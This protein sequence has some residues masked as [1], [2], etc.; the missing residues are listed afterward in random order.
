MKAKRSLKIRL[1]ALGLSVA[2]I[3]LV[4]LFMLSKRQESQV[5][6]MVR[7]AMIDQATNDLS[8][9]VVSILD[10]LEVSNDMLKINIQKG[11]RV[12]EQALDLAGGI[13]FDSS[14]ESVEWTAVNQYTSNKQTVDLPVVRFGD[15]RSIQ[16]VSSFDD[17][18]PI[19]D[20]I[21][22]L[23]DDT[24]TIFQRMNEAGD[25]L[26]IATTVN[27][28]GQRA[29]GTYIPAVNPDGKP[30]PVIKEIMAGKTFRGRA[31][32]VDQYYT[33][34]YKPL[35]DSKGK[36]SGILY[37][38]LPER[39][40]TDKILDHLAE[41]KV[42]TTGYVYILNARGAD[43]GRYVLSSKRARDGEIIINAK[44]ANGRLFIQDM[45]EKAPTLAK[46]EIA[47]IEYPWINPGEPEPRNKL[48]EYAYY[49]DWDWLIGVGSYEEEFYSAVNEVE[50]TFSRYSVVMMVCIIIIAV[51]AAGLFT[52]VT[53]S[54]TRPIEGIIHQLGAGSDETAGAAGEV[55][56]ASQ[57]LAEGASEQAA[58]LEETQASMESLKDL[59]DRNTSVAQETRTV[60]V[61][62]DS[63]AKQGIQAMRDLQGIVQQSGQ[64]V[65][66]M[67][68]VIEEIKQSSNAVS[69]IIGTID[70][71]AF[72]TN[73]LALN[74]SVEAAR[75]GEAGA[76]FAVVAEEVRNLAGRAAEAARETARMIERSV[77]TSEKG[78]AA[79]EE[80]SG[81]LERLKER[82]EAADAILVS[83]ANSVGNVNTA[84]AN[85]EENSKEQHSG[86]GE[87]TSAIGQIN[88]VTQANAEAASGA[89][90]A[91][92]EL[93]AQAV[94]LQEVVRD[95]D[96]IVY[97]TSKSSAV[98]EASSKPSENGRLAA[99]PGAVDL[100]AP[101]WNGN[102]SP[103]EVEPE[104]IRS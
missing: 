15:G 31:Y 97:G 84:M 88:V 79:S 46:G 81:L 62:A 99:I 92:E 39:V 48:V 47:Q 73:I 55:S 74:A 72:Q 32:V 63:N 104:L 67:N 82:T 95:L 41:I 51:V 68:G 59:V 21:T 13:T 44:D 71:I 96:T 12:G 3:P 38:G 1:L 64:A 2:V 86:I 61:D 100:E 45:V 60:S 42:G 4:L 101:D 8:H 54:V 58:S 35:L 102:G 94:T 14:E 34:V 29:V 23:T 33:T 70:D 57:S 77:E 80:V 89:A 53:R 83:L 5:K 40:A 11:L 6:D 16:H 26:R 20:R 9:Q 52:G 22:E 37:V 66:S 10:L 19:V 17:E 85:I 28:G 24:A 36:V 30:N 93:S 25:M 78:G 90:S 65:Q 103:A 75:A 91:A 50:A 49:A 27:K 18:V 98:E 43:A 69:K 87:V 76:G 7:D 56:S